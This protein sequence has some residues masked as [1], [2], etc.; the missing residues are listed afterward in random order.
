MYWSTKSPSGECSI[1]SQS[2]RFKILWFWVLIATSS[3]SSSSSLN[4]SSS[5]KDSYVHWSKVC[6]NY[7]FKFCTR[8]FITKFFIHRSTTKLVGELQKKITGTDLEELP[9][10]PVPSCQPIHHI[11]FLRTHK[12]GSSTLGTILVS[13][14][15]RKNHKIVLDPDL[16]DMH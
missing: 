9:A 2:Q 15:V 11:Y 1:K 16:A 13:Y 6:S 12:T 10:F 7:L 4:C 3:S 8:N 14:G 5:N